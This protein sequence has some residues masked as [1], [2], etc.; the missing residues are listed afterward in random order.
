[1][2]DTIVA[3]TKIVPSKS[4]PM[5]TVLPHGNKQNLILS[6]D[7]VQLNRKLRLGRKTGNNIGQQ[8]VAGVSQPLDHHGTIT[9]P[10]TLVLDSKA[11]VQRSVV[12]EC[13]FKSFFKYI[14]LYQALRM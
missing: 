4:L 5:N 3:G 11:F 9:M 2:N 13:H 7:S 6:T 1:M 14:P 10:A 8:R 12:N